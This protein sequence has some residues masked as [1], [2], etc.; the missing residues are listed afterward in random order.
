MQAIE[1]NGIIFG[2][3]NNVTNYDHIRSSTGLCAVS[4]AYKL[5]GNKYS[6]SEFDIYEVSKPGRG[7]SYGLGFLISQYYTPYL[8]QKMFI[9]SYADQVFISDGFEGE[10]F[11]CVCFDS[12]ELYDYAFSI[13]RESPNLLAAFICTKTNIFKV[14]WIDSGEFKSENIFGPCL[15]IK[16]GYLIPAACM[17]DG[18]NYNWVWYNVKKDFTTPTEQLSYKMG[19]SKS[20]FRNILAIVD[21]D[22]SILV[23]ESRQNT[24][25][26]VKYRTISVFNYSNGINLVLTLTP[27]SQWIS[28]DSPKEVG[29]FKF[30]DKYIIWGSDNNGSVKVVLCEGFVVGSSEVSLKNPKFLYSEGLYFGELSDSPEI[31]SWLGAYSGT[32]SAM[33]FNPLYLQDNKLVFNVSV[34]GSGT[35]TG[36]KTYMMSESSIVIKE[37]P[38]LTYPYKQVGSVNAEEGTFEYTPSVRIKS[39]EFDSITALDNNEYQVLNEEEPIIWK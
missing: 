34:N 5:S 37:V 15:L 33:Y 29:I 16:Y 9:A 14:N 30:G 38:Q 10:N 27:W 11:K 19:S 28:I 6:S 22:D 31:P 18:L 3:G 39:V 4:C 13:R 8:P 17:P 32:L 12:K 25:T 7:M 23:L 2:P 1:R 36:V 21:I 20:T 26:F 24:T 35:P